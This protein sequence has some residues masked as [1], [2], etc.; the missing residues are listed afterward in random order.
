MARGYYCRT[1]GSTT[2]NLDGCF[3]SLNGKV[4]RIDSRLQGRYDIKP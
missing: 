3:S 4:L 2:Q 1:Y